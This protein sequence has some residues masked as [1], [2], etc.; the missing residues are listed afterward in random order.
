MFCAGGDIGAFAGAGD[1]VPALLKQIT[2]QLHVAVSRF[3]RM[4]APLVA[5]VN[6]PAAGAGFALACAA[7]LALA[8]DA[9][10]FSM[11]YTKI[12]LVP[13]GSST[14]FLPRLVGA[15]RSL[16]L[17]L[18]NRTLSAEEALAWGLVNRV[19]PAAA[20]LGEAE[21]LARELASGATAAFGA[22]KRLLL[23]S[24]EPGARG[25]NGMGGPR[26]RR[27][28]A[29]PRRQRR[30]RRLPRQARAAL[31]RPLSRGE[32]R[33]PA[34]GPGR[35]IRRCAARPPARRGRAPAPRSRRAAAHRERRRLRRRGAPP[36]AA[37]CR[38]GAGGRRGLPVP[39]LLR[40]ARPLRGGARRLLRAPR[41]LP[42]ER[43]ALPRL[44]RQPLLEAPGLA[45][46][47]ALAGGADAD[48]PRASRRG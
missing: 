10:K 30:H 9:A 44:R 25:A 26:H 24:A 4:S 28:R 15:R 19:V 12:G 23:L 5:A 27:R 6:G 18:T 36:G 32:A 13:D 41:R 43:V 21:A 14:W 20:L 34:L 16:E 17:M 7:D 46:R 8:S 1:G 42:R 35:R 47:H 3:A 48:A 31:R 29:Q 37:P 2:A 33:L 39:R 11:A 40:P 38:R 22:V 45:R